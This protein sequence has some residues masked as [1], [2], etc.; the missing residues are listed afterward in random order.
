[1]KRV[2]A[3]D[4]EQLREFYFQYALLIGFEEFKEVIILLKEYVRQVLYAEA[5]PYTRQGLLFFNY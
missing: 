2:L 4:E 3:K 1:M 5:F